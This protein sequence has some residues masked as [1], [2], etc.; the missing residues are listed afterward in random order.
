MSTTG[1]SGK[2]LRKSVL[3]RF[4]RTPPLYKNALYQENENTYMQRDMGICN[5]VTG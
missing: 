5:K 1:K 2:S 4:V 3:T